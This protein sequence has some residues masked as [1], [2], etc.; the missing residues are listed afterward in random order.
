MVRQGFKQV[1]PIVIHSIAI[2]ADEVRKI[3][4][5]VWA[6]TGAAEAVEETVAEAG[7]GEGGEWSDVVHGRR[8][9]V[10][11]CESQSQT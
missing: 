5:G 10:G 6:L 8:E 4:A 7:I 11:L 9:K 1:F 2:I 3:E